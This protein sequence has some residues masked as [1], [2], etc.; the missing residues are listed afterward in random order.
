M[1]VEAACA[2][3]VVYWVMGMREGGLNPRQVALFGKRQW[4]CMRPEL[5]AAL[6]RLLIVLGD[7]FGAEVVRPGWEEL[8]N[9]VDYCAYSEMCCATSRVVPTTL[10]R[11]CSTSVANVTTYISKMW[12]SLS[13]SAQNRCL[14]CVNLLHN[15][16]LHSESQV[17]RIAPHKLQ[18]VTA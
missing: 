17:V 8:V 7:E 14:E 13:E 16:V 12:E 6:E 1:A 10:T 4:V 9:A 11:D 18:G 3:G 2:A 5:M 15:A